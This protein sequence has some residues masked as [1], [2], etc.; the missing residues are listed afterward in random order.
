LYEPG[1]DRDLADKVVS[2]LK[3]PQLRVEMGLNGQRRVQTTFNKEKILA[4]LM[5][6][7]EFGSAA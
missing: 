4:Q 7:Y 5:S 3:N 1:N 6:I 2:L